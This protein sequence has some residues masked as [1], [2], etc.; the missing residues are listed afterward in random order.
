MVAIR[1]RDVHFP[2]WPAVKTLPTLPLRGAQ[3]PFRP[4]I[5][6]PTAHQASLSITNSQNLLKLMSIELVMLFN[7]L[8]LCHPLLLL[9]SIFPGIR[10]FSNESALHITARRQSRL[11]HSRSLLLP[12]RER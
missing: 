3:V 2:G 9:T 11:P 1:T 4:G 7:H 10:V 6:D 12:G 8:I 5:E